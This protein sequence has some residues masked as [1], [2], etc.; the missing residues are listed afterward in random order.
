MFFKRLK[1]NKKSKIVLSHKDSLCLQWTVCPN[2]SLPSSFEGPQLLNCLL[3]LYTSR[4][5]HRHTIY[6]CLC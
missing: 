3:F 5:N 1:L 6:L 2:A 4:D